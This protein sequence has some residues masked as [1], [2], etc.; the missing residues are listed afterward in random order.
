MSGEKT[1]TRVLVL[2]ETIM[3]SWLK[4][5]GTLASTTSIIGIGALLSSSAMQWAGFI[6][7]GFIALCRLTSARKA[8]MS[9]QQA[10]NLLAKEYG[11]RAEENVA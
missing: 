9:P 7:L 4:D 3:Q 11:V 2:H 1:E 8:H 6:M 10:A 5:A